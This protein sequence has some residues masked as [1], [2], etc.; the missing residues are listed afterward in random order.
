M[1]A[2]QTIGHRIK[3]VRGELSQKAFGLRIGLSQTAVTALENDQSEP[4]LGTF[5]SIVEA[6]GVN[7]EW[8]RTGQGQLK[9]SAA[10][11]AATTVATAA[12]P[13]L[14]SAAATV[15]HATEL[16]L[17]EQLHDTMMD[18]VRE[19]KADKDRLLHEVDELRAENRLLLGKPFDS[20]DAADEPSTPGP[21]GPAPVLSVQ[22]RVRGL[23]RYQE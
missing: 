14:T 4:R 21:S 16:I 5:N 13:Q 22:C 15:D 19:L 18:Q 17:R 23:R 3:Q 8:L 20:S 7:P 10:P 2:S 9:G 11:V 6:F 1:E 12:P